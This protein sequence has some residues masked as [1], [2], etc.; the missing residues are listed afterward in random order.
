ME[1]KERIF[2]ANGKLVIDRT[3][4]DVRYGSGMFYDNVANDIISDSTE[5]HIK[6][7]G[8]K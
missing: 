5:L 2:E 7:V 4:G 3:K 6:I 8:K 1:V